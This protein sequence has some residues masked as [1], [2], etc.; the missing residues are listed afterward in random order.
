MSIRFLLCAALLC[1]F[2]SVVFGADNTAISVV[3]PPHKDECFY[4]D[5]PAAGTKV[6]F[7]YMV[8]TGGSLDI[9]ASVFGPDNQ[10]VWA[11]EK[12]RESRILFKASLAGVHKFCFSNKMS[13]LTTKVVG[14]HIQ[15][16]EGL[17]GADKS[18]P[19]ERSVL[20]IARGLGE[21][22]NDQTYLRTR[23]RVHRETAEST[24][25]RVLLFS[26]GEIA[27]IIVIGVAHVTYLRRL[28]ESRRSV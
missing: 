2:F 18:D 20:E 22:K 5:V 21:I 14:F 28:F 12:D 10:V 27:L 4:E 13:T 9:D 16:G 6:Y 25:T 11:S 17:I 24:N 19:M 15:V 26:V 8:T 1:T 23:E 3:V 7:H